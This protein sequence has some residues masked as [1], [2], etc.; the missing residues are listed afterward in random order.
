MSD[1][2]DRDQWVLPS[3]NMPPLLDMSPTG[4]V[5]IT[6]DN[7]GWNHPPPTG[8][9]KLKCDRCAMWFSSWGGLT[10]CPIC[11]SDPRPRRP[12]VKR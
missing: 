11:V 8:A 1:I 9:T 7:S 4:G 5:N 10:T 3:D 12:M 2:D 6:P